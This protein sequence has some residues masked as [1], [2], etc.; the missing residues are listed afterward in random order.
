LSEG[1]ADY[2]GLL[3]T[4]TRDRTS[5]EKEL[6]QRARETLK[7]PPVT[8]TGIGKGRLVDVGPLVMGHRLSTRETEGAYQALIYK[9]GALV[10]RMLH[11][12]F[13]DPQTGDG[14]QFFDM[15]ADFVRQYS[16][17]SASTDDF[18]AVANTHVGQTPLARKFGYKDLNWFYRQ[19][20]LQAYLPSYHVNYS[21]EDQP[22]GSA[23]LTGTVQQEGIPDTEKWFMPLPLVVTLGKDRLG[24]VSVAAYGKESPFKVKLPTHPQKVDVDPSMWVLSEKTSISNSK[25]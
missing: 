9:K 5:S 3:Y 2:S 25:H 17:R 8:S 13:T 21:V 20:V 16:N 1:F 12:L 4:Q 23:I 24:I 15:M 6:I 22:D 11:F 14:Q 18:F 7:N 19:W 10:L